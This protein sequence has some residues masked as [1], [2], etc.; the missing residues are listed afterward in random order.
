MSRRLL[1]RGY[2]LQWARLLQDVREGAAKGLQ[3]ITFA[4]VELSPPWG[5]LVVAG[6]YHDEFWRAA[7]QELE[8]RHG[9]TVFLMEREVEVIYRAVSSWGQQ[10]RW[11]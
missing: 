6:V 9:V 3:A 7:M 8:A 1:R 4:R 5:S 10:T 2:A 11:G